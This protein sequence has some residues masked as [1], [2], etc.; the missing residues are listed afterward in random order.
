LDAQD[1]GVPVFGEDLGHLEGERNAL[2]HG[3]DVD[4]SVLFEDKLGEEEPL[5]QLRAL[6]DAVDVGLVELLGGGRH[7]V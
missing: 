4:L 7:N 5:V 6:A 3:F 1:I 2:S